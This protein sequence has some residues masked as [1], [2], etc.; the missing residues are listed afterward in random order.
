MIYLHIWWSQRCS[1]STSLHNENL[2]FLQEPGT[3]CLEG[4]LRGRRQRPGVP[5][6][7][8]KLEPELELANGYDIYVP[9]EW[10]MT[11]SYILQ[12]LDVDIHDEDD[13][14]T[15]FISFL[16][17]PTYFEECDVRIH[18]SILSYNKLRKEV[19]I[20]WDTDHL[21][22]WTVCYDQLTMIHSSGR[23]LRPIAGYDSQ[24]N[25]FKKLIGVL[26]ESDLDSD[27][28]LRPLR[29]GENLFLA[30]INELLRL[31]E[32][33]TENLTVWVH[34]PGEP[35]TASFL[36]EHAKL[37]FLEWKHIA[38]RQILIIF[39]LAV[40]ITEMTQ[41]TYAVDRIRGIQDGWRLTTVAVPHL[42]K[43][44]KVTP[45][46]LQDDALAQWSPTP[47]D[48]LDFEQFAQDANGDG[49]GEE[50]DTSEDARTKAPRQRIVEA[51]WS[52]PQPLEK[53]VQQL[54]LSLHRVECW[55]G[56][57]WE[58]TTLF[59]KGLTYQL[60]HARHECP[61]PDPK[62]QV[63]T[64]MGDN[65]V[66]SVRVQWCSC[67]RSDS[68]DRVETLLRNCWY[69][70]TVLYPQT[71]ATFDTLKA[72][73]VFKVASNMNVRDYVTSL[74][75]LM[76]GQRT[77]EVA[78]RY[79]AFGCM[80]RQYAFLMRMKQAGRGHDAGGIAAMKP[81]RVAVLCWACLHENVNLPEKWRDVDPMKNRLRKNARSNPPLGEGMGYQVP[82]REY[83]RHLK[84]Y[85]S[86]EDI[87]TCLA[88]AALAQK[89]TQLSTGLRA[90]GV[91]GCAVTLMKDRYANMDYIFFSSIMGCALL[92]IFL[93]YN[94]ACQYRLNLEAR[95]LL[96]PKKLQHDFIKTEI[97]AALPIWHGDYQ[98]GAG[99]G[100][101]EAPE[102]FWAV[103]NEISYATHEMGS[104]T[105]EDAIE[106]RLDFYNT[107]KNLNLGKLL[108]DC[109]IGKTLEAKLRFALVQE[110]IQESEFRQVNETIDK[111]LLKDWEQMYDAWYEDHDANPSPFAPSI[112]DSVT[113]AEVRLQLKRD[114]LEEAR[115]SKA[116]VYSASPTTFMSLGLKLEETQRR[117][118]VDAKLS[119]TT[120][121]QAKTFRNQQQIF[122]PTSVKAFAAEE[123]KRDADEPAP[124]A[125][126]IKLWLPS[127]LDTEARKTGCQCGG[128]KAQGLIDTV[129]ARAEAYA[130]KYRGHELLKEDLTLDEERVS[131]AEATKRLG[132]M[133]TKMTRTHGGRSIQEGS[134]SKKKKLSWIWTTGVSQDG[135]DDARVHDAVRVEW[136]KARARSKHWWEE[137]QEASWMERAKQSVEEPDQMLRS[138]LMAYASKQAFY[139]RET[140]TRF[141]AIW[142]VDVPQYD[143]EE[144]AAGPSK[145]KTMS[146]KYQKVM[147]T[148]DGEEKRMMNCEVSYVPDFF[149]IIV[150]ILVNAA[151]NKTNDP[152]MGMLKV[153]IDIKENTI[154]DS[155]YDKG[156]DI[157]IE[158]HSKE[159]C[160]IPELIFDHLLSGSNYDDDEKKLTGN[161]T[162]RPGRITWR[163]DKD[164]AGLLR[165]R[166]YDLAG[167]VKDI[168][169]FLNDNSSSMSVS[170]S[171]I[172]RLTDA[173]K[174]SDGVTQTKPQKPQFKIQS[175]HS[176]IDRREEN[177]LGFKHI[178]PSCCSPS[179]GIQ[180]FALPCIADIP[181]HN[182]E[183]DH[184]AVQFP[185][186][187]LGFASS[188]SI[189][190]NVR[191][192]YF[193]PLLCFSRHS[194]LSGFIFGWK[195][196]SLDQQLRYC[197]QR[198]SQL[199]ASGFGPRFFVGDAKNKGP[200][201]VYRQTPWQALRRTLNSPFKG[202]PTTGLSAIR[203]INHNRIYNHP[204]ALQ[205]FI[206]MPNIDFLT[207]ATLFIVAVA[208]VVRAIITAF[209]FIPW[210]TLPPVVTADG[211]QSTAITAISDIAVLEHSTGL[212]ASKNVALVK[213]MLCNVIADIEQARIEDMALEMKLK[214]L[215]SLGRKT[216]SALLEAEQRA[217][218]QLQ[219][220]T[221]IDSNT[222]QPLEVALER[223]SFL[224]TLATP[225]LDVN[226][227]TFCDGLQS[228]LGSLNNL[229]DETKK[230]EESMDLLLTSLAELTTFIC[231][232]NQALAQRQ[233]LL[234]SGLFSFL[235]GNSIAL[236]E[237]QSNMDGI[238]LIIV[239]RR[240]A[241]IR[242]INSCHHY[243]RLCVQASDVHNKIQGISK[244]S[245]PQA[246]SHSLKQFRHVMTYYPAT[247]AE[248]AHTRENDREIMTLDA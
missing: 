244:A 170:K 35:E 153:N 169:V 55:N 54:R 27:L 121:E 7:D 128:M 167:I 214:H 108:S 208:V 241:N 69:P 96:L 56:D 228:I 146:E 143:D 234:R 91:G 203:L 224:P 223:N 43:K 226:T 36:G 213:A 73:R 190:S 14:P 104:G 22:W 157:P 238:K 196:K 123:E 65:T 198:N 220:I 156:P 26:S 87:S 1:H 188:S 84:A 133:G 182:H 135:Q 83:R 140:A 181:Y 215:S 175:S 180:H 53:D 24:G 209:L 197:A 30:A 80:Q 141:D 173:M 71:V 211:R 28:E 98:D 126:D 217:A 218:S 245:D 45:A 102:R 222:L 227:E 97:H 62:G 150:E 154:S 85:V 142:A 171:R 77:T 148:Y 163:I 93:T 3:H 10:V 219:A 144:P 166:V 4:T 178:Y 13:L 100:D 151:D 60:R 221:F 18:F 67:D 66:Q 145:K 201:L 92:A 236:G 206:K 111:D 205:R 172:S 164:T 61:F 168:K 248:V 110:V 161:S 147:W 16:A 136:S 159:N 63:L 52:R 8:M 51:G 72:F 20:T 75:V 207:L 44:A 174:N 115:T 21:E 120:S 225:S 57:F 152:S 122:M 47:L 242:I 90:S 29:Q 68:E 88:F 237:V 46:D 216:R 193:C 32:L 37:E 34:F 106:D 246:L 113:E 194:P 233:A 76:D 130:E 86:E 160:Y 165:K 25:V 229:I 202:L 70:A 116:R 12:D 239:W 64:V 192:M 149:R 125:E 112:K 89:D 6:V 40:I 137:H 243:K 48:D 38:S 230:E 99:K 79:K 78:D 189:D 95:N 74:E 41:K 210:V 231:P 247:A 200:L 240:G 186:V 5:S 94:I 158:I 114:E 82:Q 23:R 19:I 49:A 103:M 31:E 187:D 59:A 183:A 176:D 232:V 124:E 191:L 212:A 204:V 131:D 11:L 127:D 42:H 50:K 81:G 139:S 109:T 177:I 101:G 118:K 195:T 155:V 105:R 58:K 17:D 129:G 117:L 184:P 185:Y 235:G 199:L 138:G 33:L 2:I 9:E 39:P 107:R 15:V 132:A 119:V 162:S 179:L 134:G